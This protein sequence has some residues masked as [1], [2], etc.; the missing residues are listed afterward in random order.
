[1]SAKVTEHGDHD[2]EADHR[3]DNQ[4]YQLRNHFDR[5]TRPA[6]PVLDG[7]FDQG[8]EQDAR[9]EKTELAA[10]DKAD[11]DKLAGFHERKARVLCSDRR[12]HRRRGTRDHNEGLSRRRAEMVAKYQKDAHGISDARTVLF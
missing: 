6:E 11:L 7:V 5:R 10:E 3:A 4:R 9:H 12:I 2:A 1:V 8:L